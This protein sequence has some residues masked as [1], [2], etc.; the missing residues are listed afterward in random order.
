[1]WMVARGIHKDM[2]PREYETS[3]V[4]VIKKA[5]ELVGVLKKKTIS[6]S[7]KLLLQELKRRQKGKI[8]NA[9]NKKNED[10]FGF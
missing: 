6:I 7:K 5:L 3:S 1:M 8:L 4:G 10:L 9:N 2:I